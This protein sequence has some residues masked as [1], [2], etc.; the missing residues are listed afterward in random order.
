VLLPDRQSAE[1][2]AAGRTYRR[3]ESFVLAHR[4]MKIGTTRLSAAALDGQLALVPFQ[5]R[6]R[7]DAKVPAG[8]RW[9]L[10]GHQTP[11]GSVI[12][13]SNAGEPNRSPIRLPSH[14]PV[15]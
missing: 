14:A 15:N 11:A 2:G 6:G 1:L 4:S 10:S 9:F 12:S 7:S 13:S 5:A 3:G 8:H